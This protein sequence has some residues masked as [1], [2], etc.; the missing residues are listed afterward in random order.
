MDKKKLSDIADVM[1]ECVNDILFPYYQQEIS[2]KYSHSLKTSMGSGTRTYHCKKSRSEHIIVFGKKMILSKNL[3]EFESFRF[4]SYHEIKKYGFYDGVISPKT[5]LAH[6]AIH[7][8]AHY[9]QVLRGERYYG[10]VHNPAFYEILTEI[11]EFLGQEVL[12]RFN[13]DIRTHELEFSEDK[14]APNFSD[15]QFSGSDLFCGAQILTNIPELENSDVFVI[16]SGRKYV[17]CFS[18]NRFYKIKMHYITGVLIVDDEEIP[19]VPVNRGDWVLF[20]HHGKDIEAKVTKIQNHIIVL[21]N[22]HYGYK[23]SILNILKK[24]EPSKILEST[25]SPSNICRGDLI[26]FKDNDSLIKEVSV[27]RVNQK[28][29]SA[30]INEGDQT[31]HYKIPYSLIIDKK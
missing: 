6:T 30:E 15:I 5:L 2:H 9:I 18:D 4:L 14:K 24:I 28:T 25:F 7:E 29:V 13:N 17:S 12:D 1:I 26:T 22:E 19:F 31:I 11:H 21:E 3:S 16:S 27:K 8:F 20:K 10:S 23:T